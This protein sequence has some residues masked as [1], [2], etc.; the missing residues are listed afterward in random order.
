M[1]MV[2]LS[3]SRFAVVCGSLVLMGFI[4]GMWFMQ[5]VTRLEGVGGAASGVVPTGKSAP[6]G[7]PNSGQGPLDN[8]VPGG[9]QTN[10]P[11][12]K[13]D[14]PGQN[15]SGYPTPPVSSQTK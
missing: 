15:P 3:K 5:P 14:L 11:T 8:S 9:Y 12:G 1:G 4:L 7:Q 2:T 10:V 6:G 13:A